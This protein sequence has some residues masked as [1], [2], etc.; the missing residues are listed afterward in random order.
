MFSPKLAGPNFESVLP[1][2]RKELFMYEVDLSQIGLVGIASDAR[3]V[4]HGRSLVRIRIHA[5]S[6]AEIDHRLIG[7]RKGVISV[8]ANGRHRVRRGSAHEA[9]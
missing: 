9:R 8:A 7:H 4:A 5:V 1:Q 6:S 2:L 3:A